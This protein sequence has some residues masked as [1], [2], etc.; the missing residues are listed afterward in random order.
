MAPCSLEIDAEYSS[1]ISVRTDHAESYYDLQGLQN[2]NAGCE[3]LWPFITTA[4]NVRRI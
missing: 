3:K 1:K 2:L 4:D